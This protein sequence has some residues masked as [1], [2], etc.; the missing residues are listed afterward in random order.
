MLFLLHERAEQFAAIG[1][2]APMLC[3]ELGILMYM[4][5]ST[6]S[7]AAFHDF[8][9][10]TTAQPHAPRRDAAEGDQNTP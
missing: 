10:P 4:P 2:L 7:L 1:F 5:T 9:T 8:R 3:A 6:T